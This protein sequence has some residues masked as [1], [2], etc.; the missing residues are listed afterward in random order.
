MKEVSKIRIFVAKGMIVYLNYISKH[1]LLFFM[2][3]IL[4][5]R[6]LRPLFHPWKNSVRPRL[7]RQ[8]KRLFLFWS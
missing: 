6:V 8:K 2:D 4:I 3:I 7:F 1:Y 5:F